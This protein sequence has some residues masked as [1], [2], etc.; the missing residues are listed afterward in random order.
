[1]LIEY[2][3]SRDLRITANSTGLPNYNLR[4]GSLTC[5]IQEWLLEMNN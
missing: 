3:P 1:M 5:L 2:E 4:E